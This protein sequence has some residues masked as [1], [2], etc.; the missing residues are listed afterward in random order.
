MVV[1]YLTFV[2]RG[3]FDT[4]RNVAAWLTFSFIEPK[5]L[6]A[7][8]AC[9]F[10]ASSAICSDR[11]VFT[12]SVVS[13]CAVQETAVGTS[14]AYGFRRISGACFTCLASV[15][16]SFSVTLDAVPI[17]KQVPWITF[18]TSGDGTARG[19][20]LAVGTPAI[21]A[22]RILQSLPITTLS[23]LSENG[24]KDDKGDE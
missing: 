1:A 21:R 19:T 8:L 2:R 6:L 18:L 7:L 24:S 4:M 17:L 23:S 20:L 16:S 11:A 3:A 13:I 14:S 5:T 9:V 22:D 15:V 10:G 12:L